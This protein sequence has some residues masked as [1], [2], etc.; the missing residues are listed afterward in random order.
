M[1][2]GGTRRRRWRASARQR[3]RRSEN[4]TAGRKRYGTGRLEQDGG[5]AGAGRGRAGRGIGRPG[6]RGQGGPGQARVHA[7]ERGL[8]ALAVTAT[9]AELWRI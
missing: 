8:S 2:R 7:I 9:G 6:R 5:R 4:G 1:R 3:R